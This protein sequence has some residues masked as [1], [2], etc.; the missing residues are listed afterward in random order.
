MKIIQF[1]AIVTVCG[2]LV[3]CDRNAPNTGAPSDTPN[4]DRGA[5]TQPDNTKVN[6]RDRAESA[7]TP[8]DQGDSES[9][10]NMTIQVRKALMDNDQL[11]TT[12]KNI[13]VITQN[14]KTTLRGPVN[15]EAEKQSIEAAVKHLGVLVDNQLEVK[16]NPN[17]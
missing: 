1:S 14:G 12:A 7:L 11:S 17:P 13:K 8:G 4:V 5:Y 10:R 2:L 9:D 16:T 6:V 3:G 15:S